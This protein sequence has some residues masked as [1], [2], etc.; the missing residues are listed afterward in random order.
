MKAL[1]FFISIALLAG[2]SAPDATRS[3][4]SS[5]DADKVVTF[6]DYQLFTPNG[7]K[8]SLS[9]LPDDFTEADV[10]LVGEWHTHTGI[11]RFQTDLLKQLNSKSAKLALSM[12]QFTRDKQSIVDEYLQS[13]IGEQTLI[14]E[15]NA[16]PNYE[17]D[18]RPLVEFAK[19]SGI[20]VIA[21]NAPKSIVRC[22]GRQGLSYLDK[23]DTSE[24]QFVASNIDISPSPYK[25]KFMASMHHGD[26]ELTRKQYAA[27]LTWDATMAE[28]IVHYLAQHPG[29]QVMH[30]AGKFHTENGL[31]T[32]AQIQTLNPKLSV[33]VITPVERISDKTQDYQLEVLAP[34]VRY[35][36][37]DNQMKAYQSLHSRNDTL[38]CK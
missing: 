30:I 4:Q 9:A 14:K 3:I 13:S 10:I 15:A 19:V 31:G 12:E 22:I 24:R 17:S 6:V 34:P 8:V 28:S 25:D 21:S 27:Q 5:H 2:C 1:P 26:E 11:H 35:V 29:H 7:Q 18:Y 33:I 16:W 20:D 23:L 37:K 38:V 36:K 32:A